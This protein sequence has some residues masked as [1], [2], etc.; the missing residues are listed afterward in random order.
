[1]LSRDENSLIN[2]AVDRVE[3]LQSDIST[4]KNELFKLDEEEKSKNS[5]MSENYRQ[6]RTEIVRVISSIN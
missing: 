1:M 6:T 3:K 4:I 5:E 2:A